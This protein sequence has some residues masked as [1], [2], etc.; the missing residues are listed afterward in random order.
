M[1]LSID[2][3]VEFHLFQDSLDHRSGY[4]PAM[5]RHQPAKKTNDLA[6][7]PHT[8][9]YIEL[10]SFPDFFNKTKVSKQHFQ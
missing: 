6:Q 10:I 3:H 9:T 8:Y 7:A 4:I 1:Q 2:A 5:K